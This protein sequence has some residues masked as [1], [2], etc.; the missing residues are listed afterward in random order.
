MTAPGAI[1]PGAWS[2]RRAFVVGGGPSLR[3]FDWGRLA[4]ERWIGTNAASLRGATVGLANDRRF[5]ERF[6]AAPVPGTELLWLATEGW[7]PPP[8]VR[9]VDIEN[10]YAWGP[11]PALVNGP[12]TGL[13]A[14][15]LADVLGASPVYLLGFDMRG[16][17]GRSANFHDDY[18]EDWRQSAGYD[19]WR[20]DFER[21]APSVR[22]RVVNLTPGSA[23]TCFPAGSPDD[24]L[25]EVRC[26]T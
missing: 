5:V 18:P 26:A 19:S 17:G 3:G 2:G 11:G 23:L 1:A 25:P 6:W 24:V 14:L 8:H 16:E 12:C 10:P 7:T 21:W 20:A 4:G 15:H 13:T 22:G 9:M